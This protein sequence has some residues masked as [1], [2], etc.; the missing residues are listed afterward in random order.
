VS[1]SPNKLK[2]SF[3]LKCFIAAIFVLSFV[4]LAMWSFQTKETW[5]R[6]QQIDPSLSILSEPIRLMNPASTSTNDTEVKHE[7]LRALLDLQYHRFGVE[8]NPPIK[9]GT[10]IDHVYICSE[11]SPS[12][13]FLR[14]VGT[15]SK[16]AD[17]RA[18]DSNDCDYWS[19]EQ[20]DFDRDGRLISRTAYA[21]P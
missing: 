6:L 12:N 1:K 5:A 17:V 15:P 13:V 4:C 3:I 16:K 2:R 20:L 10:G 8:V 7:A 9:K 19:M 18:K 21:E 11:T 14:L